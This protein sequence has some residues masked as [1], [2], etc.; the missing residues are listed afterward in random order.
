[1]TIKIVRNLF[2]IL[3]LCLAIYFLDFLSNAGANDFDLELST[4]NFERIIF[5][6]GIM[7]PKLHLRWWK[8][9]LAENFPEK[10]IIFLDDQIY[11]YW[12]DKKIEM[13][14]AKGVEILNDG[15]ATFII[16]HSFGGILAETM[17]DRAL[18]GQVVE[19]ITMASPH[20]LEAFGV[21]DAKD[22][23]SVPQENSAPVF[24]FGGLVDAF[25]L[26]PYSDAGGFNHL[27]LWSGHNGFLLDKNIRREILEN[28]FGL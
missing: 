7:T 28:V 17:I 24:S 22:F 11:F 18:N 10:E 1:M 2:L 9:D 27:N 21:Q 25:V 8:Q 12:Q 15:V 5:V 23:L 6:P 16:A 14:V 26:F 20:Q 4:Q 13:I 3:G 19:L